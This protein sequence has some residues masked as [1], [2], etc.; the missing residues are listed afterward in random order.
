ML[1]AYLYHLPLILRTTVVLCRSRSRIISTDPDLRVGVKFMGNQSPK[2]WH[3]I[4][5]GQEMGLTQKGSWPW[6]VSCSVR[7]TCSQACKSPSLTALGGKDSAWAMPWATLSLGGGI[8]GLSITTHFYSITGSISKLF[9]SNYS[10]FQLR[11]FY[12]VSFFFFLCHGFL[13]FYLF[14]ENL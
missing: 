11:N 6:R 10:F 9:F 1:P 8:W 5:S 13:C 4:G 7:T 12:W 2:T 14:Q 3:R